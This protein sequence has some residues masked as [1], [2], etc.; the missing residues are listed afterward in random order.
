F[1]DE[2][3]QLFADLGSNA[4]DSLPVLPVPRILIHKGLG[5]SIDIGA[6]A[7]VYVPL[8]MALYGG[9][10]KITIYNPDQGITWALRGSYAYSKIDYV[11]TD[12]FS[13]Q[14]LISRKLNF[15]DPYLGMGYQYTTGTVTLPLDLGPPPI[16]QEV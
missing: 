10:I 11:K 3:K 1:P 13:P 16:P 7:M 9:D 6:S 8:K 4:L 12:T 5:Q 15:A 14:I 2:L